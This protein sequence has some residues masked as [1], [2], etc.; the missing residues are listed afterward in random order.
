MA[1]VRV[2]TTVDE[3]LLDRARAVHGAT[4]DASLLEAALTALLDSH[5]RAEVDAA[6]DRAY[7]TDS[8]ENRA[9]EPDAWGDL[10]TWRE[11]ASTP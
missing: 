10:A 3:G 8:R 9:S 7:S 11:R 1:K 4:T 5:R 2:S 6:Y